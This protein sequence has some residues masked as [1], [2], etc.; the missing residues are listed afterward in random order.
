MRLLLLSF[1]PLALQ[2]QESAVQFDNRLSLYSGMS[3]GSLYESRLQWDGKAVISLDD[4]LDLRFSGYLWSDSQANLSGE[5]QAAYLREAFV[6]FTWQGLD[7]QLG[8]QVHSWSKLDNLVNF[9]QVTARDF[10]RF[11]LSN[12]DDSARGQWMLSATR[13]TEQGQWQWLVAP[14]TQVHKLP[15]QG[16]RYEFKAPRLRFGFPYVANASTA[17]VANSAGSPLVAMRYEGYSQEWQWSVQAR[18][19]DDFEPLA[20]WQQNP[21]AQPQLNTFYKKRGTVGASASRQLGE[22]VLRAELLLSPSRYFNTHEQGQLSI[23]RHHQ[24]AAGLGID[25]NGPW[26]TFVN[27]QLVWDQ[28]LSPAETLVRPATDRIWSLTLRRDFAAQRWL[29][30]MR[31]YGSNA[32]DGLIRLA[33]TYIASDNLELKAGVDWFYGANNGYFGQYSEL[34]QLNVQAHWYF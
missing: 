5:H 13:A 2:A 34:D 26:D 9:E 19:G 20:R 24:F 25:V 27:L 17:K 11:I 31:W 15:H 8:K 16:D 12:F 6:S 7:W 21:D 32:G 23:T 30:E 10:S 18:Y 3:D 14:T 22:A 4:S 29:S 33:L 1:L 28:V